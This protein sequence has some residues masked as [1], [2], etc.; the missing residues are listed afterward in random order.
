[1][2]GKQRKN[3]KDLRNDWLWRNK[4]CIYEEFAISH[5]L[6]RTPLQYKYEL[7]VFDGG[8]AQSRAVTD[9][10]VGDMIIDQYTKT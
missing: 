7:E 1:M 9:L 10:V 2:F 4:F 3:C 5:G 6:S 8:T